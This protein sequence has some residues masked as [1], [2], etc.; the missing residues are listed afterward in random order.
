MVYIFT[1]QPVCDIQISSIFTPGQN[2]WQLIQDCRLR[3][4]LAEEE[5]ERGPRKGQ[6]PSN[7]T[8]H[9]GEAVAQILAKFDGGNTA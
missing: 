3:T 2:A 4:S 9:G 1:A 6:Q 5:Q 8:G 7:P